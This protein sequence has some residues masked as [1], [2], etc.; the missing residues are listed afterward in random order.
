MTVP[1][2]K[3]I[4]QNLSQEEKNRWAGLSQCLSLLGSCLSRST[5][6]LSALCIA[7]PVALLSLLLVNFCITLMERMNIQED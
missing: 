1:G 3:M 4:H 7:A 2:N 5:P 6:L